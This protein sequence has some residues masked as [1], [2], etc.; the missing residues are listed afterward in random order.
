MQL[1]L[2]KINIFWYRILARVIIRSFKPRAIETIEKADNSKC[3][4]TLVSIIIYYYIRIHKKKIKKLL[5]VIAQLAFQMRFLKLQ[6]KL[7]NAKC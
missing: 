2:L 7:F 6:L 1:T 5:D 4:C 3:T